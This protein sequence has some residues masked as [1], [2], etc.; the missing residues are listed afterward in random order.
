MNVIQALSMGNDFLKL[1]SKVLKK[2]K[3]EF[4]F[5]KLFKGLLVV[6]GQSTWSFQLINLFNF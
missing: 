5:L 1:N 4:T 6:E 2:L 3:I